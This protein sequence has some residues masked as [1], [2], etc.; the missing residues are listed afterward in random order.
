M[1]GGPRRKS[2]P[3]GKNESVFEGNIVFIVN[4]NN[5]HNCFM[6]IKQV[7]LLAGTPLRT[8]GFCLEQSFTAIYHC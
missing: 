2:F 7:H 1:S 6:A 8:G 3:D 4:R 5:N